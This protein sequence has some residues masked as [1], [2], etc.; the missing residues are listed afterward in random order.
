MDHLQANI[1]ALNSKM[2]LNQPTGSTASTNHHSTN[3]STQQPTEQNA[4]LV[5]ALI[6]EITVIFPKWRELYAT[7]ADADNMRRVWLQTLVEQGVTNKTLVDHGLR[8]CRACGWVRPPAAG[9]FCLWAW[10][11]AMA[12]SGIPTAEQALETIFHK[13]RQ[14][15]VVLQGAMYHLSSILDWHNVKRGSSDQIKSLVNRALKETIEHWKRGLPFNEPKKID[16]A[17]TLEHDGNFNKPLTPSQRQQGRAN[18][19]SIM[20]GL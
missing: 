10:E 12:Q 20:A 1:A 5:N 6:R 18:L 15:R 14:P 13:I 7:K 8:S 2:H 16:P 17:K 19:Q 9:Q 4:R 3:S 11:G